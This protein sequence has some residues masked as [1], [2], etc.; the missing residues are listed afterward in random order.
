MLVKKQNKHQNKLTLP[1]E[2][3]IQKNDETND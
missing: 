2:S 3:A 1:D